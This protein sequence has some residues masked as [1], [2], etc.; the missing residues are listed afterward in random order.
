[1]RTALV[2]NVI[3]FL[4]YP[5]DLFFGYLFEREDWGHLR[6]YFFAAFTAAALLFLL[7]LLYFNLPAQG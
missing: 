6:K 4:V 2:F 1:M 7:F 3:F 5:S